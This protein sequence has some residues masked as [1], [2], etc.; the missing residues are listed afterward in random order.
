MALGH[1]PHLGA[2]QPTTITV[3][4]CR[5]WHD[6]GKQPPISFRR[7]AVQKSGGWAMPFRRKS[8]MPWTP[9][10]GPGKHAILL[11]AMA[12]LRSIMC[13]SP[14]EKRYRLFPVWV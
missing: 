13:Y 12:W 10:N 7:E 3:G 1:G 14:P 8:V 11:W 2:G 4:A 5:G 9:C 6:T